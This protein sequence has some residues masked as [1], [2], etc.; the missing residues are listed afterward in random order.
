MRAAL[1]AR[2]QRRSKGS[3]VLTTEEATENGLIEILQAFLGLEVYPRLEESLNL[4]FGPWRSYS[5]VL[6]AGQQILFQFACLLHAQGSQLQHCIVLMDEP[7]NHLH[8]AVL[9]EV[10]DKI[11]SQLGETS[12]LWIATHSVPLIAHVVA[13]D[14]DSL[15]YVENGRIS[16]AGRTPDRVLEGLMGGNKGSRNLHDFT[17]L[18]AK[19][20][21]LTFL[22]ECLLPPGVV[23]PDVKDPQTNQ[24]ATF[25]PTLSS[26][27]NRLRVLDFGAGKARLLR[28]LASLRPD[29]AEWLDYFAF[30]IDR[31]HEGERQLELEAVYGDDGAS[32]SLC[33]LAGLPAVLDEGTIDAI[34]MCNVLHEISP[35]QWSNLFGTTGVLTKMLAPDGYL[36]VV[37]D[38]GISIGE[39]A[40]E[41]GFLLLD[42]PEL[43]MLFSIDEQDKAAGLLKVQTPSDV[44][45]RDRL[46]A[47]GIG[48]SC[49]KKYSNTT[50]KRA[51]QMLNERT[52]Q[53]IEAI[54]RDGNT[55]SSGSAGRNYARTAQLMANSAIW[56]RNNG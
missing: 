49:I 54:N 47:Y 33:E 37:E 50:R 11:R 45:Y 27:K 52:T 39:R 53:T 13:S 30:D 8:P 32:R 46:V 12:Q 42:G 4:A 18:P 40:H 7:E 28:T 29:V 3:E 24:I 16:F 14:P 15:W 38:Y 51:I 35:A 43:S 23:G 22:G 34:V 6:S 10:I 21:A 36:V 55:A 19:Y 26:D 5:S 56:L 17:L 44:R 1:V 20:A 2:D 25:L 41:Y 48:S 9:N 31:S